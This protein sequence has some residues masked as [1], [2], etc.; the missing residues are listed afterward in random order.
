MGKKAHVLLVHDT[1]R[2]PPDAETHRV[3]H[4]WVILIKGLMHFNL[5]GTV[6]RSHGETEQ[7]NNSLLLFSPSLAFSH[8]HPLPSGIPQKSPFTNAVVVVNCYKTQRREIITIT[9]SGSKH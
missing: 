3:D 7:Y 6:Y 4:S 5:C 2:T 8:H 1:Q 9:Q